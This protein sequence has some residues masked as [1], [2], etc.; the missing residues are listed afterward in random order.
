[1]R[2][3]YRKIKGEF[4]ETLQC[5]ALPFELKHKDFYLEP[6]PEGQMAHDNGTLVVWIQ[7]AWRKR[8]L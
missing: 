6:P 7:G 1:M 8:S 4:P 5:P 2:P 3:D